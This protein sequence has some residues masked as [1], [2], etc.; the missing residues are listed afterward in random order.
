MNTGDLAPIDNIE[1][2]DKYN[3]SLNWAISNKKVKNIDFNRPLMVQ[4]RAA[5]L[6]L[7]LRRMMKK[8]TRAFPFVLIPSETNLLKS[9]WPHSLRERFWK[10]MNQEKKLK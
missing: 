6:K 7:F 1:N 8:I 3:R 10:M 2:G 4:A 9:L 5:L